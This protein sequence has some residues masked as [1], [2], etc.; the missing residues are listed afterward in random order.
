MNENEF[1]LLEIIRN[2]WRRKVLF[3]LC[4]F[5]P[6]IIAMIVSFL[7][8][9]RYMSSATILAPEVAAG[10]GIIQ[11]P[12]GGFSTSSLGQNIISSQALIAL[13]KSDEMLEDMV[14]HF[15]LAEKLGFEK[16]REA[17]KFVKGEMTSIEF[18]SNEGVINISV[19]ANSREM[20]KSM[21]EF[22]ISNLETLNTT[23]ELSSQFPIVRVIS[24]PYIPEKKSFPKTKMNMGVAGFLG[25][26]LGLFYVYFRERIFQRT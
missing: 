13:L 25:L 4:F 2:L 26:V 3:I 17:M 1:D 16:K 10:G 9:K 8:P 6:A 7:L 5:V 11:T 23:F 12:F 18:L 24:P 14:E 22:Y 15:N 19:E 21:V 20:S